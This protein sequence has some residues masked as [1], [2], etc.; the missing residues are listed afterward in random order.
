MEA[1]TQVLSPFLVVSDP[2]D[3]V[4]NPVDPDVLADAAMY[5]DLQLLPDVLDGLDSPLARAALLYGYMLGYKRGFSGG[6]GDEPPDF[7]DADV[8]L[9]RQVLR[10]CGDD[11]EKWLPIFAERREMRKKLV[12]N[13]P[14]ARKIA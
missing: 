1:H 14:M 4:N 10:E 11:P 7:P 12:T 3:E 5:L 2:L 13:L 6:S 8:V 9:L